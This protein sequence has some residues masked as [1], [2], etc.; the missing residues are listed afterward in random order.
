MSFEDAINALTALNIDGVAQSF[1]LDTVPDVLR[2]AQL[3]ALVP[4]PLDINHARGI[5]E[6]GSAFITLG[7]SDAPAT[8][9]YTLTHLLLI[10]PYETPHGLRVQLPRLATLIDAY[11]AAIAGNP[12]LND[13]LHLPAKI[14]IDPGIVT[15]GGTQYVGC[16][17]RHR[18]LISVTPEQN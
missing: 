17:F 4:L 12:R 15:Y 11:S 13:T 9:E 2:R 6:Q 3:P 14:R 7:F 16:A 10:S 18:W 1:A 5:E 8:A